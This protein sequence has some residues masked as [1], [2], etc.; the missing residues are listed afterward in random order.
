MAKYIAEFNE[1]ERQPLSTLTTTGR[2][3]T[4]TLLHARILLKADGR[5]G[6]RGWTDAEIAAALDT[7][8]STV[9]RV[10][11]ALVEQGWEAALSRPQPTGRQ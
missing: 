5:E 7:S 3:A 9:P 10:R 1:A 2:A 8:E 4:A 11:Q 6:S